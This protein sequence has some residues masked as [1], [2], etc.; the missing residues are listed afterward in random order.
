[1]ETM[2]QFVISSG[3]RKSIWESFFDK[4]YSNKIPQISH[5]S[6]INI[7]QPLRSVV[8]TSSCFAY[9]WQLGRKRSARFRHS[10]P[11]AIIPHNLRPF[12][13]RCSLV[14]VLLPSSVTLLK[15][16]V[17]TAFTTT[18]LNDEQLKTMATVLE[19]PRDA[20]GCV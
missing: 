4:C 19:K 12:V 6:G 15:R 14:V 17:L 18:T 7:M 9:Y 10:S 8:R 2:V 13:D 3:R 1:M 5:F 11:F 20:L 16:S